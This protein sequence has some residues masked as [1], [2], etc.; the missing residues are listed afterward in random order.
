MTPQVTVSPAHRFGQPSMKG[1]STE[2]LAD[3]Y[4][5]H[6]EV[7]L[8]DDYELTRHELLVALWFE[9]TQ[10]QPRFRKRWKTW[11]VKA[12]DALWKATTIDP[13]TVTLPPT[14]GDRIRTP[15]GDPLGVALSE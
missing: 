13:E 6:G 2:M 8:L 12:G 10:G 5:A 14:S 7:E 3:M 1:I 11:A 4:W 9:A 15:L